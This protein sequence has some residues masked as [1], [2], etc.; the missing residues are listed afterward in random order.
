MEND[1]DNGPNRHF[2]TLFDGVC[3]QTKELQIMSGSMSNDVKWII[4]SSGRYMFVRF[5][6]STYDSST[7]FLAKIHYGNEIL[8]QKLVQRGNK[9][10]VS[11]F[12]IN[13]Q[14]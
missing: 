12:S 10:T 9:V 14:M 4:S 6:V 2:V 11:I 1:H 8:N 13:A 3:D 7:G 5:V